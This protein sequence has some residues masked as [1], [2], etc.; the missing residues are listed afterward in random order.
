MKKLLV[1]LGLF[2][3]AAFL[4]FCLGSCLGSRAEIVLE[5]GGGGKLNLEYRISRRFQSIGALDGNARWPSVP[6]DRADFE[7]SIARLNAGGPEAVKLLSF[8]VKEDGP[9]LI[10]GAVIG[11][12][13]L[14]DILPL[15][16]YGERPSLVQGERRTL[17]LRLV[18]GPEAGG[19]PADPGLLALAE[20]ALRGYD[21]T[22]SLSAPSPVE[23][24]IRG[25]TLPVEQD[26][27]KAGFS[28]PVYDL[29]T[30][31]GPLTAEFVF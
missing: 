14:E 17:V 27:R 15:L 31:P 22:V 30:R 18:P 23:L 7:R 29:I 10:Y 11:F 13:R 8:S 1:R 9:D 19:E 4:C 20:E 3:F 12:S 25:G 21:L 26:G 16:D 5:A 6:V 24:R 2:V 28:V